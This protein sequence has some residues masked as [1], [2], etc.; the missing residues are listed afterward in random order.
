MVVWLA[1][2]SRYKSNIIFFAQIWI[3][4][5]LSR[6][7]FPQASRK[8]ESVENDIRNIFIQYLMKQ[9]RYFTNV[10][11]AEWAYDSRLGAR[12]LVRYLKPHILRVFVEYC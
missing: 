6:K 10:C 8:L 1:V 11:L 4:T 5:L 12:H 2:Y 3:L 7:I 9:L